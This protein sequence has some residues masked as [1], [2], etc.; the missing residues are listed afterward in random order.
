MRTNFIGSTLKRA[1]VFV[2]TFVV[3]AL[4]FSGCG[5]DKKVSTPAKTAVPTVKINGV[6]LNN[7]SPKLKAIYDRGS[8]IVGNDSSYPPFGFIDPATNQAMGVEKEMATKIAEKL[9]AVLGKPIKLQFESMDFGAVLSSLATGKIDLICSCCT[10]T[11]ERKKTMDFSSP[12]LHTKDV[13]LFLN[14]NAGKYHA[15]NDFKNLKIA[16]NTGSSQEVRATTLSSEITSTP[17]ISDGILQLKSH[18]VDAVIVDNITGFRYLKTNNDLASYEISDTEV[19]PQDKAVAMQKG[20]PDLQAIVNAVV[21]EQV[22]AGNVNKW[23][24]E[25]TVKAVQMGLAK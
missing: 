5:N 1:I 7:M 2:F 18:K 9:T 17:T 22:K 20:S 4:V 21:D 13:F 19:K 15:L 10:V 23:I 16:A 14:E 11:E 3:M 8:V 6:D 24:D 12:Y 25:Y